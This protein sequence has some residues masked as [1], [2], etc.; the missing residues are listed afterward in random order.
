VKSPHDRYVDALK[1]GLW[2]QTPP[3]VLASLFGDIETVRDFITKKTNLNVTDQDGETALML[4]SRFGFQEIVEILTSAAADL[5]KQDRRGATAL[6]IAAE[7]KHPAIVRYL[8]NLGA[9]PK[10]C[11]FHGETFL[12]AA[13]LGGDEDTLDIALAVSDDPNA[14][15]RLLF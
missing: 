5:D 13:S 8:L 9:N 7:N 6:L 11:T 4:A 2:A 3:L 14:M 12:H 15:A 1:S 10:L